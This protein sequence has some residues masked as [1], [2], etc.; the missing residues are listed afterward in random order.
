M[1]TPKDPDWDEF[2]DLGIVN[3]KRIRSSIE[4]ENTLV[5]HRVG[6]LLTS[7]LFLF[8]A[9]AAVFNA[10]LNKDVLATSLHVQVFLVAVSC[11][12]ITICLFVTVSLDAAHRQM[13][14]LEDWWIR[15]HLKGIR[16]QR[17]LRNVKKLT[18]HPPI[19]G[20]FDQWLYHVFGTR[21]LP[22]PILAGWLGLLTSV[23]F[24]YIVKA[25]QPVLWTALSSLLLF[26]IG[27]GIRRLLKIERRHNRPWNFDEQSHALEPPTEPDS[28]RESSPP[29]Q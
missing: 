23:F 7:Q 27:V 29:A 24:E 19:N 5:N 8:G 26:I 6:W 2:H 11:V 28:S 15:H 10:A 1:K 22:L 14:L 18:D 13:G 25:Q 12:A 17:S 4:H 9:F 21:L 3:W 16:N 20:M